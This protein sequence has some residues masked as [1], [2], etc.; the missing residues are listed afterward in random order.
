MNETLALSADP[1]ADHAKSSLSIYL[2]IDRSIYLSIYRS[3]R[4]LEDML[5]YADVC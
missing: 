4:M 5:T 1:A 2:S 3:S